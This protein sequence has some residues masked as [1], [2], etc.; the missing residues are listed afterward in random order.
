[1]NYTRERQQIIDI[2]QEIHRQRLVAGTW[3]NVSCRLATAN[4]ILI[5]PSGMP[6]ESLQPGDLVILA[7]DGTIVEGNRK[8]SSESPLHVQIYHQRPEVR[9]IVHVHSPW[10]SAYAVAHQPIPMLLEESAQVL[11]ASVP[12]ASYAHAGSNELAD[13]ACEALGKEH[14]AVLL[15]NHGLVGLGKDL[16]E[17]LLVCV[18]AEKT[19]MIGLLAGALGKVNSLPAEDVKFLHQSFQHYGQPL[20]NN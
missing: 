17:A 7:A 4:H 15:A 18:I 11:G 5:T 16:E 8:P 19:A 1:M 10:A 13:S 3:G 9:A 6:Y 14:K 20:E 2:G 12:V